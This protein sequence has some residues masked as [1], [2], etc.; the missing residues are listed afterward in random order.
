[1]SPASDLHIFT[2]VQMSAPPAGIA[3]VP[4]DGH[5][6]RDGDDSV[7]VAELFKLLGDPTR[8]RILYALLAAGELCVGDLAVAAGVSETA[9]SHSMRLLRTAAVVRNRR[10]G[11]LV[12]YRLDDAHV[13]Q[14]L[15]LC[16]D[17]LAH[18]GGGR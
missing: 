4:G 15:E 2:G 1:L 3:P 13:R 18:H 10:A 17:H 5:G 8:V 9:V 7:R 16:R 12:Y 14:V 11:R 6:R